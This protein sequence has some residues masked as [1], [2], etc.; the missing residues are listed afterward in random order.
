MS[1]EYPLLTA[2][3]VGSSQSVYESSATEEHVP[4]TRAMLED[5]RVYYYGESGASITQ[6]RLAGQQAT[7]AGLSGLATET[8]ALGAGRSVVTGVTLGATITANQLAGGYLMSSEG[9]Y[10]VIKSHPATASGTI[11]IEIHGTISS[12]HVSDASTTVTLN[13]SIYR[14]LD[15]SHASTPYMVAGIAMVDVGANEFAWFQTWGPVALFGS[16][17]VAARVA[18]THSAGTPGG[19][20]VSGAVTDEVYGVTAEAAASGVY[21]T[22]HLQIRP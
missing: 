22:I 3:G 15:E 14:N 10:Y 18:V 20:V 7:Q 1:Y 9:A 11:D 21:S 5:G 4:G 13:N 6:G 16:E 2:T 19:V 12:E 17:V 8:N